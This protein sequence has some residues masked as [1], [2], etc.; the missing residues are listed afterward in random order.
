MAG[1]RAGFEFPLNSALSFYTHADVLARLL[2][3]T[4]L[5]NET[6][7]WSSSF[8]AFA[9]GASLRLKF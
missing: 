3:V 2:N 1:A 4:L 7:E 8:F 6:P 9:V 5:V